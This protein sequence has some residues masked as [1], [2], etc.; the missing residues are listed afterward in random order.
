MTPIRLVLGERG[1]SFWTQLRAAVLPGTAD[2]EL[3]AALWDLVWAGEV[4]NDSLAPLRVVTGTAGGRPPS[5][6]AAIVLANERDQ[7][8]STGSVHRR[9]G[10][11]EPRRAAGGAGACTDRGGAT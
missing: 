11:V 8:A 6:R 4:T 7:A 10:Q 2:D 5:G 9:G 3:L 1:A